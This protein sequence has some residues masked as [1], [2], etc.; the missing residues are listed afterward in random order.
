M[1]MIITIVAILVVLA[2]IVVSFNIAKRLSLTCSE[3]GSKKT[4]KTGN[5]RDINR[6]RRALIAGPVPAFDFEYE[7]LNCGNK[8]WSTI[9]NVFP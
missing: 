8:F 3:C 7:C 2:L 4:G 6:S 5:K 1:P 9:E